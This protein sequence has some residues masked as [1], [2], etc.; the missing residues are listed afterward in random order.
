MCIMAKYYKIFLDMLDYLDSLPQEK[1]DYP[2]NRLFMNYEFDGSLTMFEGISNEMCTGVISK[3]EREGYF[4]L[5]LLRTIIDDYPRYIECVIETYEENE[6]TDVDWSNFEQLLNVIRYHRNTVNKFKSAR[7]LKLY[8]DGEDD[9][10]AYDATD[11]PEEEYILNPGRG[12]RTHPQRFLGVW[13]K[14]RFREW[15]ETEVATIKNRMQ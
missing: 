1:S 8:L 13:D 7:A 11:D 10:D 14:K 9:E 6:G 3:K 5:V 15:L 12:E 4:L 2:I